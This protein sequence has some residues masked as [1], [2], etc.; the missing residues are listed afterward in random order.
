MPAELL[1]PIYSSHS[2]DPSISTDVD[3]FVIGLAERIDRLQDAEATGEISQLTSLAGELIAA[4]EAAGFGALASVAAS[5][6]ADC[7]DGDSKDARERLLELTQI[8][9]RVRLGYKG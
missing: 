5:L 9:Q 7:A 4:A 8:A 3:R 2:D 6:E 1:K